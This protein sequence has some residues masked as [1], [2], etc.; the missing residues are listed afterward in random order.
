LRDWRF[1]LCTQQ[2]YKSQSK[3]SLGHLRVLLTE[4]ALARER[5]RKALS[6]AAAIEAAPLTLDGKPLLQS[7]EVVAVTL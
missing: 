6:E 5:L 2:S 7:N 4:Y 1:T 3:L